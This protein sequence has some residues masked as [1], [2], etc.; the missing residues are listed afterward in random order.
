MRRALRLNREQERRAG[1]A[2][3]QDDL[4]REYQRVPL[5]HRPR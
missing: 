5:E 3:E 4:R 2:H 1:E